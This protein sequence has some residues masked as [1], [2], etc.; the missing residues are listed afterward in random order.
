MKEKKRK[1]PI[2]SKAR[3]TFKHSSQVT[4]EEIEEAK[5]I[6]LDNGGEIQPFVKENKSNE[7]LRFSDEAAMYTDFGV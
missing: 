4:Q 2:I 7:V 5:K 3:R 1:P 6:F